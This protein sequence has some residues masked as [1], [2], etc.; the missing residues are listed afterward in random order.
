[1]IHKLLPLVKHLPNVK[2][3]IFADGKFNPKRALILLL[4]MGFVAFLVH[5]LGF[6]QTAQVIELTDEVSDLIGYE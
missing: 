3:W 4:V 5:T 1:M 6:E 2:A